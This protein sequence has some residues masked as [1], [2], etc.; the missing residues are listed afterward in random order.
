MGAY[1]L[2]SLE[3]C[4]HSCYHHHR[5]VHEDRE[6]SER[7]FV[8]LCAFFLIFIFKVKNTWS[9]LSTSVYLF[10]ISYKKNHDHATADLV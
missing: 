9:L 2:E 10:G 4:I 8:S 7:L 6:L 3:S 1:D 5:K